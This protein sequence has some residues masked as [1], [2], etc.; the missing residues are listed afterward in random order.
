M[1]YLTKKGEEELQ[2]HTPINCNTLEVANQKITRQ[3]ESKGKAK[4]IYCIGEKKAESKGED[5]RSLNTLYDTHIH[6]LKRKS[7]HLFMALVRRRKGESKDN[8][9]ANSQS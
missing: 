6:L 3:N 4:D 5:T 8:I 2:H 9:T 7:I 1:I